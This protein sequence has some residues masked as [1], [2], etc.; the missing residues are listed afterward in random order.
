VRKHRDERR[1]TGGHRRRCR[2]VDDIFKACHS[3]EEQ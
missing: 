3:S 1:H 2:G